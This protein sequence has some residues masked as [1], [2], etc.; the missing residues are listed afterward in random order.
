M[1]NLS[2][3]LSEF[4]DDKASF[5]LFF[6]WVDGGGCGGASALGPLLPVYRKTQFFG[7]INFSW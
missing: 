7:F 5:L 1:K 4:N 2:A 3:H 6:G